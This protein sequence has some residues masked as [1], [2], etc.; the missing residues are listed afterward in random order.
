MPATKGAKVRMIGAKRDSTMVIA[1][2]RCE[3][4]FGLAQVIHLD[5]AVAAAEGMLTDGPADGVVG[6]VAENGGGAQQHASTGGDSVPLVSM[7]AS[8]PRPNSSE[9]PG[10]NGVTTK[11]VSAKITRNM[12]A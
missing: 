6:R 5:E 9:S 10:R 3:P 12:I 1:P 11:P 4:A 2:W 8:A 7:A